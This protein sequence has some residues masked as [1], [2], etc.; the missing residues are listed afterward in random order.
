MISEPFSIGLIGDTHFT[1]I[2]PKRRKDD[3]FAAQVDKLCQALKIFKQENC[4]VT[5]QA[6]DFF[7]TPTVANRVKATVIRRLRESNTTLLS[8]WGQ[9]DVTGH[10]V[11][12][13]PN[14]PIRVLEAAGV[15]KI[16]YDIPEVPV[17]SVHVYGSSFGE[18]VPKVQDPNAFN[19]LVT[20]RMIGDRPLFPGQVLE[21]PRTFLRAH[22]DYQLVLVGDYHYPF[23]ERWGN[24]LIVNC[25]ALIRQ[26]LTD[27]KNELK[28]S[29]CVVTIPSLELKRFELNVEPYEA[30]FDLASSEVKNP[31]VL[32]RFIE[33]ILSSRSATE[34]WKS[35][36]LHVMEE[37]QVEQGVK[38]ELD[39]AFVEVE[40]HR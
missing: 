15:V 2:S 20:H 6:G 7:D 9:H 19:V 37:M 38:D 23:S 10:S 40:E 13:L 21:E 22:P 26:S 16:L 8:V 24:Q 32:E 29:V 31:G 30:V 33:R 5:L 1:N 17:P 35:I 28:P 36:L 4:L 3:F 11:N 39:S 34:G 18:E 12:T 27:W 14:S 25:G